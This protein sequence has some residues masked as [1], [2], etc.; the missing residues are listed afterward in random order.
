MI[1]QRA[2]APSETVTFRI[3]PDLKSAL[4]ELAQ[5][6]QK[7]VG[8]LL[9]EMI[10][11]YIREKERRDFEVEARR[12]SRIVAEA[13]QDSDSDEAAVMRE[14]DANFDEFARDL[15]ARESAADKTRGRK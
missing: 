3:D 12:Q 10:R 1:R 7:P 5:T 11:E 8:A 14:L 4:A 15:A 9:R 6:V 13:A 2:A